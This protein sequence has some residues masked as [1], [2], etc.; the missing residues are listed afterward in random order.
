MV[1]GH[2]LNVKIWNTIAV[3]TSIS[4][5]KSHHF[6]VKIRSREK[7]CACPK[8][9]GCRGQNWKN[10]D[11]KLAF[12]AYLVTLLVWL[13]VYTITRHTRYLGRIDSP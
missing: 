4:L 6:L 3:E 12:R 13:T 10:V 11:E 9:T 8:I 7:I 1:A 5:K 2:N